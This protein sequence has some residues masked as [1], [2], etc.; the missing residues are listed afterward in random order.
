[1]RYP[2]VPSG[3]KLMAK[4]TAPT[5]SA[6]EKPVANGKPAAKSKPTK[7]GKSAN[8]SAAIRDELAKN[9]KATSKEIVG[10]LAKS[11]M[12]VTPTLV[13]YVKSQ[14]HK[15][16]K[17]VKRAQVAEMSRTTATHNPVELVLRVKDMAR[18]V[19][20]IASLKKLVDLLAE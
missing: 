10:T 5:F 3:P 18:E 13:Y 4:S 20:G 17:I 14:Q 1:L 6:A 7:K 9:P 11:G 16:K 19:G 8:R 2:R 12:K 15:A